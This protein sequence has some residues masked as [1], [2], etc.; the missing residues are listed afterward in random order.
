LIFHHTV[1]SLQRVLVLA[2]QTGFV[3]F[4]GV[5]LVVLHVGLLLVLFGGGGSG[6]GGGN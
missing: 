3:H 1:P 5:L 4:F 6:G 2:M